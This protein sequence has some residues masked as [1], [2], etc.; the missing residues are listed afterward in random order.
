MAE[1]STGKRYLI[2]G[3]S[4]VGDMVMAQSLFK[5]LKAVEPDAVIDVIAPGWSVPIIERMPEVRR[6]IGL[7][8]GHGEFNLA[9]RRE[10][11]RGLV[12]EHY[13]HA[14]VLPR[15]FKSA[16]VP[17]FAKARVRT[18][19]RGE[20]RFGLLND[21]R[22]LDKSVLDQTVKRF[23]AL[24]LPKGE[25]PQAIPQPQLRIDTANQQ[26]LI[27]KHE[28]DMTR[29]IVAMMPGASYGPAKCWP[30]EYFAELAA[31]LCEQDIGVWVLGSKGD[32]EA[33]ETIALANM[34]VRNL[35]GRTELEDTVDLLALSTTAVTNDSGLMHV[36]AAAGIHVIAM[37]GSSTPAYTPALTEKKTIHYL[38]LECSPCFKRECPLEH[39]NCLRDIRVDD[40]LGS[41]NSVL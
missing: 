38:D 20:M 29:P 21:I 31:R 14:L 19:Y 13:D 33:G 22:P 17:W 1:S 6:G 7:P 23:V 28:L 15:S 11:G 18:G 34:D 27:D 25:L 39:L 40:V 3:P 35:C 5:T 2:V 4:W 41:V 32:K 37:Y 12:D 30:L 10:I 26:R 36:A 16:L 24:G 8:V 9:K